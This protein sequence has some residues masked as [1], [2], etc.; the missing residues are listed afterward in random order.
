M[1]SRASGLL[2]VAVALCLT[3]Q[4]A[5]AQVIVAPPILPP[6]LKVS[7]SAIET[8]IDE[9]LRALG[10]S[11]MKRTSR[12]GQRL[13]S[14][15]NS[16]SCLAK[17]GKLVAASYV[18]HVIVAKRDKE[19]LA[20]ITI[21]DSHTKKPVDVARAKGGTS[22]DSVELTV[23]GA[24]HIAG[25]VLAKQ[26]GIVGDS[27][28]LDPEVAKS[29]TKPEAEEP[30]PPPVRQP[31]PDPLAGSHDMSSHARAGDSVPEPPPAKAAPLLGPSTVQTTRE[32]GLSTFTYA[33]GGAAIAAGIA[34]SILLVLARSD[35]SSANETPQLQSARRLDLHEAAVGK[36]TGGLILL[37]TA[38][39]S[40][41][42]AI[43][44]EAL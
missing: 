13:S 32:G 15:E 35:A 11:L 21:V 28:P 14:C 23:R 27:I 34:G 2:S 25:L 42:V 40:I 22:A 18:L 12:T 8:A 26:P 9:E 24:A 29:Q 17:E 39:A 19:V 43:L 1:I 41:V 38:A 36:Q 6:A 16:M 20:Q 30:P 10:I 33:A 4:T 31:A 44:V 5:S 3:G 7:A 37:G